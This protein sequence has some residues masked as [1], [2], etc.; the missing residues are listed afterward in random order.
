LHSARETFN[1]EAASDRLRSRYRADRILAISIAHNPPM[2]FGMILI[3]IV[4]WLVPV[5]PSR[6]EVG[7][8]EPEG[9]LGAESRVRLGWC[10]Y[11]RGDFG[12]AERA[13]EDGRALDPRNADADVGLGYARLQLGE[14]EE[15]RESFRSVLARRR[16]D[17]DA[18]KGL[19]LAALRAPG[20]ELRFRD[21]ESPV[22][23][24]EVP[25]RAIRDYLE[26][27]GESGAYKP[28]FVKGVNLGTALPGRFPTEFP[29]ETGIYLR[30]LETIAGLG[31]NT[32]RAYTLLP[33]EFYRA[34]AAHNAL[35]G[36]RRLWLIQG[37]WA[38]LP[39]DGDF[40]GED[41]VAEFGAEIERAIDA[42]HG[43]L[44][45]PPRPGHASGIYDT[46][47]SGSL[48]AL[49][50]GREWEPFA[51]KA[52]DA[53]RTDPSGFDGAYFSA[54]RVP[55]MEAW[56][57]RMCDRTAAY[58]ARRYRMLHPLAFANWPTLDP[59]RHDTES[60]R[61][62][63]DRWRRVY[64]LPYEEALRD[65]PWEND[66][67]ALDATKIEPTAAMPAGFFAA[68]H[69]YP[70]YPDF[71][72][73]ERG[74][75]EGGDS[76]GP[77]RY[78]AYLADLKRYHGRQPVLVA[79]LGIST[80][81]G[82]AHI[83]P[84]GWHHGGIDE[85][86]QGELLSR[87]MGAIHEKGLAGGILFEL[88]DEWFK[89]T[90]SA[91]PLEVPAERRRLW[92]D[93]QSPEQSYGLIANRPSTPRRVDG[94]PADWP[95][96]PYLAGA[97]GRA[98]GWAR[99]REV[100]AAS[101]EGYLY[102]LLRTDGGPQPPDWTRTAYTIAIDTYDPARGATRVPEAGNASTATG[103]EF[104]VDLAGRD[105]SFVTV[106]EP[107]EPY[108]RVDSG[109][110]ASPPVRD[111]AASFVHLMLE[112][113]RE[114]IGRDGTRYPAL[115]VDRGAL[116]QGS[117]DPDAK[118]FDTLT[119]FAVGAATGTIE[120]R[121]PWALLNVTDPSSR[122]VLHQPAVHDPPFDTIA[123]DGLRIYAFARDPASAAR[124]PLSRLPAAGDPA[125]LFTWERW[126]VPRYRSELKH[127][128]AA[129]RDGLRRIPDPVPGHEPVDAR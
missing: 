105:A 84:E 30:W 101:D 33:P 93:A 115:R 76:L 86:R 78:A 65:A 94:D 26:V 16:D 53:R 110:V 61:D 117:L 67:V 6:P 102:L 68:Y 59:L 15:A 56:A 2:Y 52:F 116:R 22:R 85:R 129:I 14:I 55:A 42:V 4:G 34:L 44:V 109:P 18:R 9:E 8:C 75:A 69:I 51:V 112:T 27:R 1:A 107:Y 125:P 124:K 28:I 5:S 63:E 35:A 24:I 81:R 3:F 128:A 25:V 126:D 71:L 121:L 57:A 12:A 54:K 37:V 43:D 72:N 80:S 103:V 29:R 113:N 90:W 60:N 64:G 39:T 74:L 104:L 45:T 23:P 49:V 19:S 99:L 66:A 100:G 111:A 89:G 17:G 48:L 106:I 62:E 36:P 40:A 21:D 82:V 10:L 47:V 119:D 11:R 79:E 38:E 32:V 20:E 83:Q 98:E 50:I 95:T 91:S 46:D 73:L 41:Y 118:G 123:T 127:G 114:R 13:F 96:R 120:L 92:F 88:M 7:A 108:A 70:N 87:M 31:A 97:S 77:S 58:E 122:R